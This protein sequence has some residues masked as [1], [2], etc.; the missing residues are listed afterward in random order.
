M[1]GK[2][3]AFIVSGAVVLAGCGSGASGPK[4]PTSQSQAPK[5]TTASKINVVYAG[6]LANINDNVIGPAFQ[7][8]TGITYQGQG[9]GSFAMAKELSSHLITGNVF[10]SIGTAPIQSL[11]PKQTTW[12][13]RVSSTPLVIAYNPHSPDAPY[14]K[15]VAEGQVP[16]K[17]FFEFLAS[18]PVHIGR[19]NPATDPQG[20]AFYEM[21]ELAQLRYHL[22]SGTVQKILGSWNNPRQVYSEEGLPTELQSGGLDI[23][24]AFL[25]EVIQDKLS[26]IPL[27][28]WLNFSVAKNA[29]WYAKASINLPSGKVTGGVLAV[30]ATALNQ[31]SVGTRFVKYLLAH[32][33]LLKKYGYPPLSPVI[34]GTGAPSGIKNG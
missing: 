25:P 8:V 6:S 16:L 12:A 28:G 21:M 31:S 26:Y 30:W 32:E 10:E 29:S 34:Q 9:G 23:A 1:R 17:N 24:S 19:T 15:R 7:K 5:S 2:T 22:P 27:P 3:A 13:V 20:Q 14:F 4:A 11:E 33:N 18:H